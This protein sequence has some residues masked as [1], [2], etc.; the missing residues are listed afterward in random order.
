MQTLKSRRHRGAAHAAGARNTWRNAGVGRVLAFAVAVLAA[1]APSAA[2]RE[3]LH[4][5]RSLYH[6]ILVTSGNGRVCLRFTLRDKERSQSCIDP[7]RPKRMVFSYTRMMMAA[8]LLDP[9]P[10]RILAVGLGGGTLPTALVELL[11]EAEV[12]AVEID[13][14]VATAAARFFGFETSARLRLHL[15]DARVFVKRAA[16]RGERFDLVLLD[17][18]SGDYIPEHLMTQEFLEETRSVLAPEG[19]LA[20]NTFSL[21]RLYDHES[22]TYRAAFG[23]FFNLKTPGS[24]NRIVLASN[25]VLPTE[26]ELRRNAN[27]WHRRL[28]PYGVPI[29]D[30]VDR[31][32]REVDWDTTREPLTDQYS[33]ANLLRTD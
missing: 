13:P 26:A 17:A 14:S 30:Y 7:N 24:G 12:Q 22:A 16:A 4:Q 3:V 1:A 10:S 31:L 21:S 5:E 8:L 29:R 15:G 27:A 33:P 19:V 28:Q 6:N 9:A 23:Q 32:S 18:Y 20:A 11:P 2:E 25:G